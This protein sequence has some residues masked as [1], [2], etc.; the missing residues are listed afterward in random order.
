MHC[1][2]ARNWQINMEVEAMREL[3]KEE[4][5]F[6]AGGEGV[7]TPGNSY[8]GISNPSAT[9]GDFINLYEGAVAGVSHIIERVAEAFK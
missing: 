9:G 1:A 2:S 3:K 7:C 8:G 6:V 4:L 5:L